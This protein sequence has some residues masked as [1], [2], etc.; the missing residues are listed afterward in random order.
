MDTQRQTVLKL[1]TT[2]L[3]GELAQQARMLSALGD[4]RGA[5]QLH[6]RHLQ[7]TIEAFE[8]D[9]AQVMISRSALGRSQLA[10]GKLDEAEE[11]LRKGLDAYYPDSPIGKVGCAIARE[12]LAHVLEARGDLKGAKEIRRSQGTRIIACSYAKVGDLL[13]LLLTWWQWILTS[14]YIKQCPSPVLAFTLS[15]L[16]TCGQC[17]V[18]GTV[19]LARMPGN[20]LENEAQALLP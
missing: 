9:S 1:Q 10:L 14:S 17:R 15:Q 16:K 8:D 12:T 7:A 2:I 11:I 18:I 5:E 6:L 3:T 19:L 4:H 13:L 20:G